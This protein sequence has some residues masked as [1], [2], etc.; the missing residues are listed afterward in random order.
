MTSNKVVLTVYDRPD[1]LRRV[2]ESWS[3]VAN[4]GDWTFII[5][6]DVENAK[7]KSEIED[8]SKN[9]LMHEHGLWKSLYYYDKFGTSLFSELQHPYLVLDYLFHQNA[10]SFIVRAEDDLVVSTDILT[11]FQSMS[12]SYKFKPEVATV[13]GFRQFKSEDSPVST[14]G[15]VLANPQGLDKTKHSGFNPLVWGTWGDRWFSY[16][17]ETWD[18]TYSTFTDRPM[19]E[20][21]WD[22]NLR[23]RVLPS[24]SKK[25]ILPSISK[26]EN[27][28]EVG[29][30]ST[31]S[32][33]EPSG[34]FVSDPQIESDWY[35]VEHSLESKLNF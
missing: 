20:S 31:K 30:H 6:Q 19:L 34:Y 25:V 3:K 22:W 8:I 15:F 12:I 1:Y 24:F 9:F 17:R 11:Y 28:G 10:D 33:H 13:H 16:I 2:L 29:V 23:E 14:V 35:R 27:I 18:Q 4:K 7:N 21:G 5:S 26:V 32:T